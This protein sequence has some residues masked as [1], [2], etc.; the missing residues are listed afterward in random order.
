LY[1][2]NSTAT[3]SL[4]CRDNTGPI[5]SCAWDTTV[6]PDGDE[7]EVRVYANDTL[8]NIGNNDT[9]I[10]ITVDNNNPILT[11]ISPEDDYIDTDGDLVFVYQVSDISP[12]TNCTLIINDDVNQTNTSVQREVDQY[13]YLNNVADTTQLNWSINCTD[14][15]TL[16]NASETRNITVNL[17]DAMNVNVSTDKS[18]YEEGETAQITTNVSDT[19][20]QPLETANVTTDII[21]GNT[22]LIWWNTSWPF[23]KQ[24]FLNQSAGVNRS[25]WPVTVNI[26]SLTNISTCINSTRIV[27][28]ISGSQQE[29]T[30]QVL[31]GD[32]STWC[33]I[34]FLA[35]VGA[36]ASNENNYFVYYGFDGGA[37]TYTDP[38]S[39]DFSIGSYWNV[40]NG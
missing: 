14:S 29:I 3:W 6:L 11:L 18:S 32:N 12:I 4:I 28:N 40:S 16:I 25:N 22:T 1:R 35:D 23:R 31:D 15:I 5:Y 7:Y 8:G 13:F 39:T 21:K 19:Y 9:H 17:A 30:S 34:V 33:E 24:I 37:P 38:I 36:S 2:Q 27:S 26:T 20:G 10:N